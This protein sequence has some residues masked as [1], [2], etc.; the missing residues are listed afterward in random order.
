M[1]SLR[2]SSASG[3]Q[4]GLFFCI[5]LSSWA[6]DFFSSAIG[7]ELAGGVSPRRGRSPPRGAA[8]AAAPD[9]DVESRQAMAADE[10]RKLDIVSFTYQPMWFKG[11]RAGE[12]GSYAAVTDACYRE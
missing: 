5:T 4:F 12:G 6:F 10:R 3:D 8:E 1:T 9:P 2:C 7:L 11:R